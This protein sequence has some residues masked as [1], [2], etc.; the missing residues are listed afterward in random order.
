MNIVINELSLSKVN[1]VQ[2]PQEARTIINQWVNLLHGLISHMGIKSFIV[3]EDFY[4]FSVTRDYGIQDWF[5]D[6]NV[7][8]K[9]K[10]FMRVVLGNKCQRVHEENYILSDFKVRVGEESIRGI[11]CLIA[12][13]LGGKNIS[14]NTHSLWNHHK[15]KGE[16][17]LL[18]LDTDDIQ[19][20]EE[21]IDNL[22]H[23]DQITL[24]QDEVLEDTFKYISS[25]QDLWEKRTV[26]FPHLEFC[27]SVKYQLV[28]D[29]QNFHIKQILAKF[30]RMNMYF[31]NEDTEYNPH[32][33]GM[34]ARTESESV[35]QNPSLKQQRLFCKPNGE[36]A[37]FFDHIS[38]T[39]NYSGRIHF[40]P[41]KANQKCYIG[42][43]GKHL[44]TKRF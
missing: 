33:L 2:T 15:I 28:E 34:K 10:D 29:S 43:V 3:T 20:T 30:R 27:E 44:K 26:L 32:I 6:S 41:D 4:S 40:L 25:G 42:Y 8:K 37:Y 22:F 18:D 7:A 24:L 21:Q 35:Q 11:G 1:N 12:F 39:G 16:Y 5:K 17:M 19:C 36:T 9:D 31:G 38:F 23:S 14:L 13:E